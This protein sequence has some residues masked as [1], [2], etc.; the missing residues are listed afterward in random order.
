MNTRVLRPFLICLG[1]LLA[2]A[3]LALFI[4]NVVVLS[5]MTPT[6]EELWRQTYLLPY[7]ILMLSCGFAAGIVGLI[8]V[9]RQHERTWLVWF[10][11]LTGLFVLVLV[12]GE[13]LQ[14]V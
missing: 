14:G 10:A 12:F 11:I 4:L 6:V 7:V 2:A 9:I 3:F 8:A 5:Y 13:L 1:I